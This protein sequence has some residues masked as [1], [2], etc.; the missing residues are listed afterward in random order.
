M[1]KTLFLDKTFAYHGLG[2]FTFDGLV[3]QEAESSTK[4]M[5][6]YSSNW[7]KR[8]SHIYD[9]VTLTWYRR[10]IFLQLVGEELSWEG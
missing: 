3:W 9:L 2:S 1:V 6:I 8:D 10:C 4:V 5:N 7:I